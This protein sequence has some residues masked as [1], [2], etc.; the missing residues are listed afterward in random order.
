VKARFSAPAQTG[1]GAHLAYYTMGTGSFQGVERLGLGAEVKERVKIC[2]YSP[3]GHSWPVLGHTLLLTMLARAR[4][5]FIT[6]ESLRY[7]IMGR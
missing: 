3:S 7:G 6:S 5:G 2:L 1:P 4:L